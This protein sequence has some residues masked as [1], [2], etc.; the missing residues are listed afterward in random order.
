MSGGNSTHDRQPQLRTNMHIPL[1]EVQKL[2]AFMGELARPVCAADFPRH[3]VDLVE[4]II[5]GVII[6]LD[7]IPTPGQYR[8]THNMPM[9]PVEANRHFTVLAACYQENPIYNVIQEATEV[10]AVRISDLASR[11]RFQNTT[12]YQEMFRHIGI[13]HQMHVIVPVTSGSVSLSINHR[14]DFSDEQVEIFRMLAPEIARAYYRAQSTPAPE[15]APQNL[16]PRETEVLRWLRNGKR[17][18]EIAIILGISE[19]T[20]EKHIE[21]LLAKLGVESR[22]A[23]IA[24]TLPTATH[25]FQSGLN[26][27]VR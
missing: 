13:E 2:V 27:P 1:A 25:T 17:N 7:E 14:R 3:I 21:H 6:A 8:L 22:T 5:P 4:R 16:T 19:R 20:V 15:A 10:S 24:M 23:A 9:D 26:G 11:N 18:S 12:L